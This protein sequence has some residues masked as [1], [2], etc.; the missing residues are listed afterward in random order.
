MRVEIEIP[1]N[2]I[3]DWSVESFDI[4]EEDAEFYNMRASFNIG[5]RTVYPGSYKRLVYKRQVVMSNTRSEVRDHSYFIN[6]AIKIGGDILI[7]GLGLGVCLKAIADGSNGN[8]KSVTVIEKYQEVIDL[9]WKHFRSDINDKIIVIKADAL[10]WRPPKNKRYTLV[11]HDIWTDICTDNLKEMAKL[12]RKYGRK[13]DWQGSW[14]KELCL[15]Y[16]RQ[17][18]KSYGYF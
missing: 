11:W 15:E 18:K 13:T 17:E 6:R 1:D 7:N 2:K 14:C 16:R 12:H 3:G 5:A 4:S 10:E 8:L 9:V